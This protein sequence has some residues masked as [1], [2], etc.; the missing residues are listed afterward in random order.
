MRPQRLLLTMKCSTNDSF[1]EANYARHHFQEA[2]APR[3]RCRDS[4]N[5]AIPTT[6]YSAPIS[7]KHPSKYNYTIVRD[8]FFARYYIDKYYKYNSEHIVQ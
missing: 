7:H 2:F 6:I 4:G 1:E 5:I 8:N 3:D